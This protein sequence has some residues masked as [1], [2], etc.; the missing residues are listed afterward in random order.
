MKKLTYDQSIITKEVLQSLR[1]QGLTY[2]K[3][4]KHF[5][6]T[7]Y[8]IKRAMIDCG[9]LAKKPKKKFLD[10][11]LSKDALSVKNKDILIV[12]ME[13]VDENG[14][15]YPTIET[16]IKIKT[17]ENLKLMA[18][19]SAITV[20]NE[21]YLSDTFKTYQGRLVAF[22]K[23]TDSKEKVGTIKIENKITE[24]KTL[25]VEVRP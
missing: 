3:I 4:A 11:K 2:A 17:S 25:K 18:L 21:S 20:T 13:F 23:A 16:P 5:G 8:T 1:S 6:V 9:M 10:V 19:G 24:I 7:E 14:V 22:I 15:I 12:E